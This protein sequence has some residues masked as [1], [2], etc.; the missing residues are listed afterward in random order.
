MSRRLGNASIVTRLGL[1]AFITFV[2]G[3]FGI[4]MALSSPIHIGTNF[5]AHV[6]VDVPLATA[7]NEMYASG[8]RSSER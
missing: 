7:V 4:A 6:H 2:L 1:A 5:R 8:W 3:S